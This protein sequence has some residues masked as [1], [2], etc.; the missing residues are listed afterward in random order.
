MGIPVSMLQTRME[1]HCCLIGCG[2]QEGSNTFAISMVQQL[3][4]LVNTLIGFSRTREL[5]S[6]RSR[7]CEKGFPL[8]V[9][10]RQGGLRKQPPAAEEV[11][12][13]KSIQSNEILTSYL[14]ICTSYHSKLQRG[15]CQLLRCKSVHVQNNCYNYILVAI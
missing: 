13:F 4:Q 15:L 12:I 7:N 1:K 10:P 6:G 5:T 9:D 2:D 11:L 14:I 3:E 8:V